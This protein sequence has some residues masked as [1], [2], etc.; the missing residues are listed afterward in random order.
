M[1]CPKCKKICVTNQAL[2]KHL[3][4]KIPCDKTAG[5]VKCQYCPLNY[6]NR[7][8]C[9][10]HEKTCPLRPEEK[11]V[12][13]TN[14]TI[15][16]E[17]ESSIKIVQS[18][19]ITPEIE[20]ALVSTTK[21]KPEKPKKTK[22][23]STN[24]IKEHAESPIIE[25]IPED[26]LPH[27]KNLV[28]SLVAEHGGE[29]ITEMRP[30]DGYINATKMC[31]SGGKLWANYFQNDKTKSFLQALSC[32]TGFPTAELIISKM[33]G[34]N[35]GTWV[36][37]KIAIHLA[38]W[39]SPQFYVAVVNLVE[40]YLTGKVTTEESQEAAVEIKNRFNPNSS[41]LRIDSGDLQGFDK[42]GDYII[43]YGE[44]MLYDLTGVPENAE[45]FGFGHAKKSGA[46]RCSEHR[47][48]TGP[49]TRV[50]D[51][52]ETP[53]YEPCETNLE[54][55]LK[56]MGRIVK[57]QI[58]GTSTVMREQF[59]TMGEDDYKCTV[60]NPLRANAESLKAQHECSEKLSFEQEKTKQVEAESSA[61]KAE[62]EVSARIA[63]AESSA[64]IAEVQA[65]IAEAEVKKLKM[66]IKLQIIIDK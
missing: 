25:Q 27:A 56:A 40:R 38:T 36:H 11:P 64:R 13:T 18:K 42:P 43:K 19:I 10:A 3:E 41:T 53:Y 54:Q 1:E 14:I 29:I 58:E 26:T 17:Q 32:A 55:R 9:T 6:S 60:L 46:A 62:A 52:V 50:I 49:T 23:Q 34:T 31:K 30:S 47:S 65:R 12:T 51:F 33:G 45:I 39:V 37:P 59:W 57:G 66:Q 24:I 28:D 7:S 61:R 20:A 21:K 35:Q 8:N 44:K 48:K 5:R 15:E 22:K 4:R 16:S 2:K 63:E